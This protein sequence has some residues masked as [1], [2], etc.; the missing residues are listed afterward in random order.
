MEADD[1]SR[2]AEGRGPLL[3]RDYWAV[4]AGC[5]SAPSEVGALLAERFPAFAPEHIARFDR[6]PGHT[7]PL[8]EG[9]ELRVH[10]RMAGEF[11]VRVLHR[12]ACSLTLGTVLGHPEAGRITFG[13]YRND[14]GDIVI[15][16]RSRA[17]ASSGRRFAEYLAVGEAM[18]TTMWA[19]YI[20][21]VAGTIGEGV[22]GAIQVETQR[23]EDEP[24]A[25]TYGPTYR[26]AGD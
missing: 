16:I 7:G 9:E 22:R 21:A 13:A 25:N 1:L 15:H 5:A 24:E 17:R 4:V 10:I 20:S 6:A 26:A 19:D 8:E 11:G 14:D 18:Q 12:D 3:Q 2:A 23:I